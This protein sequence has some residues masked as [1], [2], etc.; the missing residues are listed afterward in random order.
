VIDLVV[1]APLESLIV[2]VY[3]PE[4][5]LEKVRVVL[6][7]VLVIVEGFNNLVKV[8]VKGPA[9]QV[10]PV[11]LILPFAFPTQLLLDVVNV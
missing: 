11:T 4:N 3:P 1:V 10:T 6:F 8:R 9:P 5:K 7:V 2:R